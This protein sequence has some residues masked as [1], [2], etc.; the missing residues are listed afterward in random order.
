MDNNAHSCVH[1]EQIIYDAHSELNV[2]RI[3]TLDARHGAS[4]ACLLMAQICQSLQ[5]PQPETAKVVAHENL[6]R[7]ELQDIDRRG[8]EQDVVQSM[9]D[10]AEF[11][12]SRGYFDGFVAVRGNALRAKDGIDGAEVRTSERILRQ[13]KIHAEPSKSHAF[14]AA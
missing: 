3:K 5:E 13:W 1:C 6:G 4:H 2:H 11:R 7:Q 8:G 14:S 10:W 12:F 9:P